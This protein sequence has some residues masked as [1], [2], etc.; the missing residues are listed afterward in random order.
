[1]TDRKGRRHLA[2]LDVPT[3]P[4]DLDRAVWD[5]VEAILG[6]LADD[7]IARR[8]GPTVAR[9]GAGHRAA[10]DAIDA[11]PAQLLVV[12]RDRAGRVVATMQLTFIPGLS[13]EGATRMQIEAVRVGRAHRSGG[14][15][16]A[17]MRWALD[18]AR[19][20]GAALAQLTSDQQRVDARRFYERLGFVASHSGF[21]I[22]L[23]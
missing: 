5:D 13:R 16:T 15:G 12:G 20:R 11:D 2:T 1:V 21:K 8:R 10:F 6:L 19:R 14:L 9:P 18:E 7:E 22:S 4:V 3:G 23:D 17:M